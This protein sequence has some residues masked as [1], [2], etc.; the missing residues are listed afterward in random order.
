MALGGIVDDVGADFGQLPRRDGLS[1]EGRTFGG[2][3]QTPL[4]YTGAGFVTVARL[5]TSGGRNFR[6]DDVD[7]A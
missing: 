4:L 3:T 6:S 1:Q 5:T 7:V 2:Y